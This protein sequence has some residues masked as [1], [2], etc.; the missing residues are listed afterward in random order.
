MRLT[1]P[2]GVFRRGHVHAGLICRQGGFRYPRRVRWLS[3]APVH[4]PADGQKLIGTFPADVRLL[5]ETEQPSL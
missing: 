2:K 3:L 5:G 4:K 1:Y